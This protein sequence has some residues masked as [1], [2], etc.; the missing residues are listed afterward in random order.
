MDK[1]VATELN[2]WRSPQILRCSTASAAAHNIMFFY[3]IAIILLGIAALIYVILLGA[4]LAYVWQ[5]EQDRLLRERII[6]ACLGSGGHIGPE[7][8]CWYDKP[9]SKPEEPLQ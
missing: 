4:F 9:P 2:A 1:T 3:R 8:T 7:D 5:K 6:T